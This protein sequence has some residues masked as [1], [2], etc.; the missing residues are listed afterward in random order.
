MIELP[1]CSFCKNRKHGE[2]SCPAYPD[3]IPKDYKTIDLDNCG[4][5]YK[6]ELNRK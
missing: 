5:G 1:P 2:W 3:G 4:N 6:Q